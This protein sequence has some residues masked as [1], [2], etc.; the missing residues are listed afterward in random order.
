MAASS[1]S[2]SRAPNPAAVAPDTL[3]PAVA[4]N[5][6]AQAEPKVVEKPKKKAKSPAQ[7][8]AKKAK[9]ALKKAEK[10]LKKATEAARKAGSDKGRFEG[11]AM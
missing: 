1:R 7:K 10:A 3:P 2:V 6:A 8:R 9:K 11:G 5:G 4:G